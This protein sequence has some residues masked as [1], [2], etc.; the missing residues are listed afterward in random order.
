MSCASSNVKT[1]GK[2]D[3]FVKKLSR[4]VRKI[5]EVAFEDVKEGS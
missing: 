2:I 4:K 5:Q 1:I 3:N